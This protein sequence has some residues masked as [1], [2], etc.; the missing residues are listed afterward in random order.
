MSPR[1][2]ALKVCSTSGC[3]ELVESGR[4]AG[5]ETRADR[6]RGTARQRGYGTRWERKRDDYLAR[7]P[8]CERAAC[9]RQAT[10]VNHLD[11]LGPGG[12]DGYADHNLEALCHSHHS[13]HTA[14]EQPGGWN[15]R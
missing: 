1:R 14:R 12:P 2:R 8:F 10:D 13:Q 6:V 5:C 9:F 7:H 11:G 15:A 3:P 4:C